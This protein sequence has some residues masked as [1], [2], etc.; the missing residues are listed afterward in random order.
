MGRSIREMATNKER[1][2]VMEAEQWKDRLAKEEVAYYHGREIRQRQTCTKV[3]DFSKRGSHRPPQT[4]SRPPT[5]VSSVCFDS[6]RSSA[7]SNASRNTADSRGS[8][9]S[10]G[11]GRSMTLSQYGAQ[12][13]VI[14]DLEGRLDFER[15]ARLAAERELKQLRG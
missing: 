7:A 1:A 2:P 10:A 6:G 3:N 8:W 15:R 12:M 14:E 9:S 11:S 5:G 13:Q 4:G